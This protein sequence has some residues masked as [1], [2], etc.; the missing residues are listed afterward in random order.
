MG[1]TSTSYSSFNETFIIA[2][3]IGLVI[4]WGL[5]L[6]FAIIGAKKAEQKGRS[7]GVPYK[8]FF[9]ILK[10]YRNCTFKRS[11]KRTWIY[12]PSSFYCINVIS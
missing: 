11:I 10:F 3:I 1:Y 5:L 12:N 8:G 6:V 4:G 9:E 7:K 2:Y